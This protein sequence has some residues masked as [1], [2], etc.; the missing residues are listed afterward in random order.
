MRDVGV[1]LSIMLG[2]MASSAAAQETATYSYDVHGRLIGVTRVN[3]SGPDATSTYVYDPADNRS[4][5]SI[6]VS[7]AQ[8]A[9]DVVANDDAPKPPA[10]GGDTVL[11]ARRE[12][13]GDACSL[14][15]DAV[16]AR[17]MGGTAPRVCQ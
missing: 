4:N 13:P 17:G 2:L 5:R 8:S 12:P 3:A 9:V 15:S 16:T 7:S 10:E 11:A 1:G 14:P 6:S